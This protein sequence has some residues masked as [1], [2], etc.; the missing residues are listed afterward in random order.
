MGKQC[1]SLIKLNATYKF[2]LIRLVNCKGKACRLQKLLCRLEP[3][4]LWNVFDI[5]LQTS[6]KIE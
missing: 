6:W 5:T 3:H 1:I 2:A 4:G